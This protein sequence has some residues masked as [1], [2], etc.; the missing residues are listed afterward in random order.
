MKVK[1]SLQRRNRRKGNAKQGG[2]SLRSFVFLTACAMLA[3]IIAVGSK[4]LDN[5]ERSQVY[6]AADAEE[7]V[8]SVS[9]ESADAGSNYL[10]TGIAGVVTGVR[11]TPEPGATVK[12]I[13]TSFEQVIVGE[14]VKTVEPGVTEFNVSS[15]M[16][17]TV[18]DL[19]SK[20]ITLAESPKMMSDNDYETLLRIVEA[21]AGGEDLKGRTLVANVIMNRVK[22]PEFPNTVTEVVWE[23]SNGVPQFSPTYDGRI[24][25]VT[26][27]DETRE[28]VKQALEGVDYS[29]GALFFI[30]KSAAEK[31]NVSW[32]EQDLKKLFKYG[33]HEF[34]TY[35][36]DRDEK[37]QDTKK[38]DDV[39][40]MV[41]K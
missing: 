35:P 26:V 21:E 39:V 3:I 15:S 22:H 17:S 16:E 19:D 2:E 13:G 28:A 25:E 6:A 38:D 14:R 20:S 24:G 34:Y 7:A 11:E 18:N 36:D 32:F 31:H 23:S 40:Q 29:E 33:V 4:V 1:K 37:S 30:Q 41:K 12:R 9:S 5:G 8:A 10:P 27:S